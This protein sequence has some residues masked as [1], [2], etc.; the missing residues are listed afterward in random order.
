MTS[1]QRADA[2]K[3]KDS[4]LSPDLLHPSWGTHPQQKLTS[5]SGL[6]K[7]EFGG[8]HFDLKLFSWVLFSSLSLDSGRKTLRAKHSL[9]GIKTI[10]FLKKDY[11]PAASKT[12]PLTDPRTVMGLTFTACSHAP[13]HV[14]PPH[15]PHI[16]LRV[17]SEL[18]RQSLRH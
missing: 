6:V 16:N 17:F 4:D 3:G 10:P 11:L 13:T 5:K 8:L 9:L 18:C 12:L 2:I 7:E 1:P 15:F 14:C